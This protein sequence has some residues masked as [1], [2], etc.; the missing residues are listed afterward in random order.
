MNLLKDFDQMLSSGDDGI[1]CPEHND[2]VS[3]P[4]EIGAKQGAANN[5]NLLVSQPHD[6]QPPA[7]QNR[8]WKLRMKLVTRKMGKILRKY[9]DNMI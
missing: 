8:F 7:G 3:Q 5:D 2:E 1:D 6:N 9:Y 4:Q